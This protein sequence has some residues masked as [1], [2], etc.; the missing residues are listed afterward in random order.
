M[1]ESST[2]RELKKEIERVTRS[3]RGYHPSSEEYVT[4]C[5]NLTRLG[6]VLTAVTENE[7]QNAL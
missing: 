6:S 4:S 7:K 1:F 3:L 5:Q 2:V